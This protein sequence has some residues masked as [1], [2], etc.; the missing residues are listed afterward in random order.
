MTKVLY[1]GSILSFRGKIG[2]LIFRQLPDGTTVVTQ[3]PPPKTRRQKRRAKEKRSPAQKAHNSR[4]REAVDYA[5]TA[6]VQ[7]IYTE[8]AATA[9][10]KTAYNFALSDWWHAPE[11][12]HIERNEERIRVQA[13]DDV[14]VT[15]VQVTIMDEDGKVL[16]KGE[17]S[18]GEGDWWEFASLTQGKTIKAQAW[19]LPG[20]KAEFVC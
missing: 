20:H 7:S 16:E 17:A 9:P 4:F 11:I 18:R 19:D 6:Q 3:G 10:M 12:H 15:K 1:N 13:T 8:L 5:R 2:S 14:L